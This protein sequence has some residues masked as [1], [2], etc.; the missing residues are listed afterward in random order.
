MAK[1]KNT[2][3]IERKLKRLAK[4]FKND[5]RELQRASKTIQN[6]L[7]ISLRA[8][9]QP[10]GKEFPPLASKTIERRKRLATVNKTSKFYAA[11]RSNASFTG[12][13]V[14]KIVAIVKG[15]KIL[16]FGKGK[17]KPLKGIRG[18]KLEGSD[19]EISDIILGFAERGVTLLGA[20]DEARKRVNNQF[21][22]FLRRKR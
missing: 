16:L 8:G 10:D 1:I 4:E 21:R 15:N 6:Q 18:K 5:N 17:H 2:K 12:D 20:T 19:A 7:R 9:E 13:F 14:R 3:A 22:R 11:G